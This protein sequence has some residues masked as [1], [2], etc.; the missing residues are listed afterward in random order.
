MNFDYEISEQD[1]LNAQLLAIRNS[2]ARFVRWGRLVFPL[3]GV[4]LLGFLAY[5]LGQQ[6]F[7]WRLI[8]GLVVC[9][10]FISMPLLNKRKQK[11]FYAKST[12]MHGKLSI[13]VD[14][15]GLQFQGPTFSSRVD[16][17]HFCRFVEDAN[18]FLLYQNPQVFNIIPKRGLSQNQVETLRALLSQNM[19]KPDR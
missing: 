3:S 6:G 19:A 12:S 11:Q 18:A 17:T 10:I 4:V 14:E 9:L 7:S 15:N 1:F 5:A 13:A 2:S 8:P 16:W